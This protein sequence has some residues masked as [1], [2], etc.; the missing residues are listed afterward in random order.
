MEYPVFVSSHLLTEIEL[1][2]DRI[3]IIQNGQ[4]IDIREMNQKEEAHYYIEAQPVEQ[5]R[6]L[7]VEQG[8]TLEIADLDLSSKWSKT[9]FLQSFKP[10]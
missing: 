9:K 6:E 7:L 2:C 1:M 10:W 5:T 4:L 3:A 8:L